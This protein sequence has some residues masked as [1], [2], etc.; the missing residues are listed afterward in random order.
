MAC[1]NQAVS[2]AAKRVPNITPMAVPHVV[3][4]RDLSS[5]KICRSLRSTISNGPARVPTIPFPYRDLQP[6]VQLLSRLASAHVAGRQ[7]DAKWL[8][9]DAR[10]QNATVS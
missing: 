1:G 4:S 3:L 10:M 2:N 8:A 9:R 6:I 7:F 5:N